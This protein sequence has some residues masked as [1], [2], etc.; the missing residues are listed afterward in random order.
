MSGLPALANYPLV[1]HWAGLRPGSPQGVPYI[2]EYREISGL[3]LNT[4][5]YRNGVAM[6]PGSAQLL[7]DCM[8]QR[9]GFTG[10]SPY[11]L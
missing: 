8:L 1:N 4:G 3:Y 9:A 2:C 10:F 6:G 11:R 5:H 7:A